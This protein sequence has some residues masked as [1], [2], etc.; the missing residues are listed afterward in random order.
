MFNAKLK[1][2]SIRARAI[3]VADTFKR[4]SLVINKQEK[5]YQQNNCR[6]AKNQVACI[7]QDVIT[8]V[9]L[10]NSIVAIASQ[11]IALPYGL[12]KNMESFSL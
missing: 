12:N 7:I 9:L 10:G 8:R 11:Q 5:N 2:L 1:I 3:F 4:T 6:K